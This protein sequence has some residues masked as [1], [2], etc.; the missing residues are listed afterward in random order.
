MGTWEVIIVWSAYLTVSPLPPPK[1]CLNQLGGSLHHTAVYYVTCLGHNCF[2]RASLEASPHHF[3]RH[4]LN[5]L[6]GSLHHTAV[7]YVTCLGPYCFRR[8][9]LE[10]APHHWEDVGVN[11]MIIYNLK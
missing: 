10:A 7:Y 4:G 8:A 1:H 11:F 2:R 5:Q 3:P 9:S 6:G